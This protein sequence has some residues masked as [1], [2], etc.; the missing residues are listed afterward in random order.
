M[1][2]KSESPSLT[3]LASWAQTQGKVDIIAMQRSYNKCTNLNLSKMELHVPQHLTLILREEIVEPLPE[4][5]DLSSS[6]PHLHHP[7]I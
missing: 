1:N 5:C 3:S 2:P 6:F 4:I 7:H